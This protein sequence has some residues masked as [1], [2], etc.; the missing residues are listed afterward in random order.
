MPEAPMPLSETAVRDFAGQWYAALD[1][2]VALEEMMRF[3]AAE[4][5]EMSFPQGTFRGRPGFTEWYRTVCH[6]F[7][8]EEHTL[9]DLRAEVNGTVARVRVRVNWQART[10]TPPA[11]RSEWLGFDAAQTWVVEQGAR[12]PAPVIRTYVCEALEPMPGSAVL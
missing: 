5:F 9:T 11:A 3:V 2:H 1:R 4:G 8:D 10:W 6:R 7:F 12:D